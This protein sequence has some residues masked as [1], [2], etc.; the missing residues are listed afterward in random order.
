[1]ERPSILATLAGWIGAAGGL[2]L[3][4]GPLLAHL[5]AIRPMQGF[6]TFLLGALLALVGLV[7]GALGLRA[8][9]GGVPGRAR[10]WLAVVVGVAALTAVLLGARPGFGLPRINDI[11]TSPDDP[12]AFEQA[13]RE[14]PNLG[15]DLGYPAPFAA[16]Q[17]AAYPDLAPIELDAPPQ[18]AL[19]RA[20]R[21]AESLGWEV[22]H[23]DPGRG[24]LEA[25]HVSWL[26][27][28]VDDVVVRVRARAGGSV[29]DVRSKSR[30]GQGDLG[31]N[32]ARIRAF[33]ARLAA[34]PP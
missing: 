4:L 24:V 33:A 29:V 2:A 10:A 30:D 26:F 21:A 13:A 19:E 9:R 20:R 15:R 34:G 8:T 32:A 3:L 22:T 11:T 12:P 28:F 1:V 14:E 16:L 6:Q 18:E 17:R 5:G 27:R 7:L 31:A 23:T 25:R